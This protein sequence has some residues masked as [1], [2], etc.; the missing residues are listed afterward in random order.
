MTRE[1]RIEQLGRLARHQSDLALAELRACEQRLAEQ[2]SRHEQLANYMQEYAR[3]LEFAQGGKADAFAIQN[4]RAFMARIESAV[5]QQQRNVD[6]VRRELVELRARFKEASI[7]A[8]SVEKLH[9]RVRDEVRSE[10]EK[11]EQR[12]LDAHATQR[13]LHRPSLAGG[14]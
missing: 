7:H 1:K 6:A 5:E 2:K 12:E 13:A 11:R 10:Q 8:R 4:Y 9:G 14:E 3:S